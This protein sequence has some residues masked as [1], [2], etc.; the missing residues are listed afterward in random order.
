[1]K[2]NWN[3]GQ[4][5]GQDACVCVCVCVCVHMCVCACAY[6]YD[7]TACVYKC[8]GMWHK[9]IYNLYKYPLNHNGRSKKQKQKNW[10]PDLSEFRQA[11]T[12]QNYC[13][14]TCQV[15]KV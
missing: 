14:Q 11:A 7:Y 4:G 9:H 6:T 12:S 8:V 5:E 2:T 15:N 1:M 3:Q 10:L 13:H